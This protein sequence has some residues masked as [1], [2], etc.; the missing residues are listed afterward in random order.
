MGDEMRESG[1]KV[2]GQVPWG[3]HFCQ[4]YKT[5]QDLIDILIPYFTAGLEHN[6]F[7]MWVTSEPLLAAEAEAALR[8]SLKNFPEYK[9][10]GQL[11][12]IPYSQWY[13]PG[14]VFDDERVLR[15]W[16]EKLEAAQARGFT[17][18]RLT[19]NTFWLEANRWEAFTQYE[20]KVND[21]IGNYDMIA[22]CTYNLEKCDASAVIDVVKNHQFA[23]VKQ[24]GKWDIIESS[25]YR[26]AKDALRLS[27]DKFQALYEDSPIGIEIYSPDGKL[28]MAN[29][30]CLEMFG[31]E[32]KDLIGFQLFENPNIPQTAKDALRRGETARFAISYDFEKVHR[33]NSYKTTKHGLI[34]V[35]VLLSVLGGGEGTTL[36]YL[37]QVQDVTDQKNDHAQIEALSRFPNENPNPVMRVDRDGTILYANAASRPL[38]EFW[39]RREGTKLVEPYWGM[40]VRSLETGTHQEGETDCAGHIYS[41]KISPI[42]EMGYANVYGTDIT[43]RKKAEESL[44]QSERDLNWAQAVSLTGSWRLDMVNNQLLWSDETYRIFEIPKGTPQTYESFMSTIYPAE[45]ERID[46]EWAE[47]QKN[48][49]PFDAEHRILAGSKIKWVREKAELVFNDRHEIIGGFGTVQDI[50]ELKRLEDELRVK[51]YAVASTLNGMAISDLNGYVTYV[52]PACMNMWNFNGEDEVNGKRASVFFADKKEG[53]NV[54]G[55]LLEE[56]GWQGEI[57][58]RRHDG[59]IFDVQ[60]L[61]NLVNDADGKPLCTMASFIDITERKKLE[62]LKDEFISLVSHELRTPLTVI[63][64]C[65]ST[66]LTEWERLPVLESQQLLRDAMVESEMLSHLVENLLE[67][68]RYQ[69]HQLS[70]YTEP[71]SIKII[72]KETLGKIKRLAPTHH[73]VTYIPDTLPVLD[74]DPLR[75][76]RVLYNLLENATK[77]SPPEKQIKITVRQEEKRLVIG[78]ADQGKGLT[79]TER[80]RLFSPFERLEAALVRTRGAGLGLVVCKRLVEAHGGEIWVESTKGR[81]STFFFSL[82]L[83]PTPKA[84]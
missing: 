83:K 34:Y 54:L 70:L 52:N 72:V 55:T 74:A 36:G 8:K 46:R 78:V 15:G 19:G 81:G 10:R 45:R 66:V 57:K 18:L 40:V 53:E 56:G 63:N 11:E 64:G 9:K 35:D 76:E 71:T 37:M 65:I 51:D 79:S 38:L 4:F 67:M 59:S 48:E 28:V 33:T 60:V 80:E 32:E 61:A 20:A 69:A 44:Q 29:R 73:F 27:E 13:V 49:T 75:V 62:Q 42:R 6:E 5:K 1:I 82:P 58:A 23:L 16:V 47:A 24:E 50:T 43:E 26:Q 77:Y 68:S 84:E 2:I 41:I 39:D 31:A 22:A 3:T 7:C 21:I 12:I 30:A 14:G 25:I 17:G